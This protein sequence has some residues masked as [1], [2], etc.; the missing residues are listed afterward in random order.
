[1]NNQLYTF[2]AK[3]WLFFFDEQLTDLSFLPALWDTARGNGFGEN[4]S[5]LLGI[6]TYQYAS[7]WFLYNIFGLHWGQI[8]FIIF[9]IAFFL[10]GGF[11]VLF[12]ARTVF[13]NNRLAIL[14][15]IFIALG[16]TYILLLLNGGQLGIILSYASSFFVLAAFINSI[17]IVYSSGFSALQRKYM[18]FSGLALAIQFLFD[19]RMAIITFLAAFL[20]FVI[21]SSFVVFNGKGSFF[22][23]VY[24]F[25]RTYLV[26]IF[27]PFVFTFFLHAFWTLPLI[28]FS[29]KPFA[30]YDVLRPSMS[31]IKF[32]S[33]ADFSHALSLLHPNWPEN[34][35]GKT[36]FLRPEFLLLPV[37][38]FASLLFINRK[39]NKSF[40]QH[41]IYAL[42]FALLGLI[43]IF[44][45]K[46]T[47]PPFGELYAWLYTYVTGFTL[48]RDPTKFYLLIILSYSVIIPY[49]IYKIFFW[50]QSHSKFSIFSFQFL[51]NQ[52]LFSLQNILVV[53]FALYLLFLI[54]PVFLGELRGTFQKYE[55]PYEYT[56]LKD[57]LYANPN[58]FR[59]LWIPQRQRFGYYSAQHPAVDAV[60][61]FN[62]TDSAAIVKILTDRDK[63][64]TT[65][66]LLAKSG[67]QYIIIPYDSQGEL[68]LDD[69]AYSQ[70]EREAVE[71][72]LD[73]VAWFL[74][75]EGLKTI[76]VYELPYFDDLFILQRENNMQ[77]RVN[78][79]KHNG[80]TYTLRLNDVKKGEK[81]IFSQNYDP[82]WVLKV[83]DNRIY[84]ERS[85][86]HNMEFTLPQ[87][88]KYTVMIEY[89][90][91]RFAMYGY[92]L[93]GLT[94]G[95][96]LIYLIKLQR[97]R[98]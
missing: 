75:K 8:E 56:K 46:G 39:R 12:F 85:S 22:S 79:E 61:F 86:P 48:F 26:T 87:G 2:S 24:L 15:S 34:I 67:I 53:F 30:S 4:L 13:G 19:I 31:V 32:F 60:T 78:W 11:S 35:F 16:N 62:A 25:S 57:F 27:L 96:F 94:L 21:K 71:Q 52:Q 33:F 44:F 93:S 17:N 43:G 1:M 45:A 92:V 58:F 82:F 74:K 88:G 90:P 55:I 81:L 20:Y 73:D 70:K 49:T 68:F 14:L 76:A 72:A 77:K 41:N 51:N 28:I 80:S 37:A 64:A 97:G 65:Q 6:R 59:T 69:R 7:T 84:P 66:A 98:I 63:S 83:N 29:Q 5:F 89:I 47:N 91:Q 42:F 18:F 38:A 23:R 40:Q 36:Y 54:R 95:S 3:D 50:L 10:L 9:W